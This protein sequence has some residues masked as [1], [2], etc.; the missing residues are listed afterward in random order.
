MWHEKYIKDGRGVIR[1][2]VTMQ[3]DSYSSNV[4]Y[5]ANVFHKAPRERDEVY[6]MTAAT[7]EEIYAAKLECW[8]KLKP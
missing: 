3:S 7:A 2:T 4:K 1:I 5:S 8:E 6:D